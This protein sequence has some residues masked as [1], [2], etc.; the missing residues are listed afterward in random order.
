MDKT[1]DSVR[2]T[3]VDGDRPRSYDVIYG[4]NQDKLLS[5]SPP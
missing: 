5:L 3:E 1:L 4:Y 2:K